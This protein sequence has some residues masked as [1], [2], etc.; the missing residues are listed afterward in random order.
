ME[1]SVC[2]PSYE[3]SKRFLVTEER[4]SLAARKRKKEVYCSLLMN[5]VKGSRY[6]V[7]MAV[8]VSPEQFFQSV[9]KYS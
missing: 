1:L 6:K 2:V 9:L 7:M 3:Q 5:T 8:V 4:A